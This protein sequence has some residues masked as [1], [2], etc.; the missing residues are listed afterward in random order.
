[1][2]FSAFLKESVFD[3]NN[4]QISLQGE[5]LAFTK[6]TLPRKKPDAI[7][8]ICRNCASMAFVFSTPH[9]MRK[10]CHD[11][12]LPVVRICGQTSRNALFYGLYFFW[13]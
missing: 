4:Y 11:K 6:R 3:L 8:L 1:L 10:V 9:P 13:V 12:I 2:Q 7:D 5:G